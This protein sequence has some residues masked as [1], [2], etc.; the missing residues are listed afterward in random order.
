[1]R[2]D[3]MT[4][5]S[6][7]PSVRRID[8]AGDPQVHTQNSLKGNQAVR[9]EG[10]FTKTMNDLEIR[11]SR[12]FLDGL[13]SDLGGV[14]FKFSDHSGFDC[15][16]ECNQRRTISCYRVNIPHN[17]LDL[18]A[19]LHSCDND[20]VRSTGLLP[21]CKR[22]L[23]RHRMQIH[24]SEPKTTLRL[25]CCLCIF[26][27]ESIERTESNSR[28]LD[29]D[30]HLHRASTRI[31]R[32]YMSH[33]IDMPAGSANTMLGGEHEIPSVSRRRG[34]TSKLIDRHQHQ[35]ETNTRSSCQ[36]ITK[37]KTCLSLSGC[38]PRRSRKSEH[39]RGTSMYTTSSTYT[40]T[41]LQ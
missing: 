3:H 33:I 16:C 22:H 15:D 41:M 30:H 25:V 31:N 20:K 29:L 37:G 9:Y 10:D 12:A 35:R 19:K 4:E 32:V 23:L 39:D 24:P 34:R 38:W 40:S 2:F 5:H 26:G 28:S 21:L 7:W 36:P 8:H 11:A 14:V 17:L 18:A 13:R 1:M 27:S 6:Q